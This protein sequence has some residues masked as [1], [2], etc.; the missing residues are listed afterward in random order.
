MSLRFGL[1]KTSLVD[2][3]GK[4]AALL[5]TAGCNLRCPYCHNPELVTGPVPPEFLNPEEIFAFLERRRSVLG[6]VVITGGEPLLHPELPAVVAEIQKLGLPVKLDTNGTFPARLAEARPDFVALDIKSA[7][8]RYALLGPSD[9][10]AA[11]TKEKIYRSIEFLINSGIP[12]QFRTVMVPGVVD[13]DDFDEIIPIVR[14]ADSYLVSGFR[15]GTTL[16][17]NFA[18]I[19]PYPEEILESVAARLQKAEIPVSIRLNSFAVS[20]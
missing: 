15:N 2:Y 16:D 1:Q 11:E 12:H 9:C 17:P 5:F 4:V 6:G 14:G 20:D 19:D 8:S 7:F 18:T 10:N 13:V 3:P